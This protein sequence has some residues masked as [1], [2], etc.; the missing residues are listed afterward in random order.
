MLKT[1]TARLLTLCALGILGTGCVAIPDNGYYDA[2]TPVYGSGGALYGPGYAQE[3]YPVYPTTHPLYRDSDDR[4]RWQKERERQ[5]WRDREQQQRRDEHRRAEQ[6][7][8]HQEREARQRDHRNDQAREQREREDARRQ[9]REH[10]QRDRQ[11]Q[12]RQRQERRDSGYD[13]SQGSRDEREN[14]G[15]ILQRNY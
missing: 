15:G 6:R 4:R 7:R 12:E 10:Q 2:P 5:A 8:E 9:Q 1:S 13:R 3:V 14:S 11:Q